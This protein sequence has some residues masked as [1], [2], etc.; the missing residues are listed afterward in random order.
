MSVLSAKIAVVGGGVA[1]V[2]AAWQ[3]AKLGATDVTVFESTARLGGTVETTRRDGFIVE[4]G[5]DGWVTEKPWASELARD[6][7]LGDDLIGS[8]DASRVTYIVQAG[9]LVPM[10]DGMRMM[11][12]TDLKQLE[13][14]ALFSDLA[15]AAY[16]TESDRADELRGLAPSADESVADFVRRHFGEEVLTKVAGPLLSGVFGGDVAKL[17]VRAVMP[18]FVAM[19]REH[20]SLVKALSGKKSTAHSTIFTSL[21]TG[22]GTLIEQM[23]AEI[24]K[25]WF[26]LERPVAKLKPENGGWMLSYS[27][28]GR[29]ADT[30]ERFDRVLLA[31]PAHSARALLKPWNERMA[32][33]LEMESSSAVLASLAFEG[34]VEI[35]RGFGFLVPPGEGSGLLAGT[36]V[37]GKWPDRAPQGSLLLRGFFGGESAAA[38]SFLSDETVASRVLAELRTLLGNL[39]EPKFAEVRR[40]RNSLPLYGVGHGE[41]MAELDAL[42]KVKPG[43]WLLGNAYRGVGLPDL[44]RDARAAAHAA[45]A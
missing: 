33:L 40:W 1:G 43:L 4:G 8:L 31:V 24:P 18:A 2:T 25:D 42:M 32:E 44:I 22:V 45:L 19:E 15:R 6:L 20:G 38:L 14:S 17:S 11:V 10:P 35:P 41:R 26:R 28:A 37:N 3:L 29:G 39:P 13:G 7:G 36:F 16:A 12:P 34:D 21:R 5:P 30:R 9:K 23:T 27:G